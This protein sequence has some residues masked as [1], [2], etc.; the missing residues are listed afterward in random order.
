[1]FTGNQGDNGVKMNKITR[2]SHQFIFARQSCSCEE[3]LTLREPLKWLRLYDDGARSGGGTSEAKL[4]T[5]RSDRPFRMPVRHSIKE[6]S[7]LIWLRGAD[8][9]QS[10]L[11]SCETCCPM[12]GDQRE[13]SDRRHPKLIGGW[14]LFPCFLTETWMLGWMISWHGATRGRRKRF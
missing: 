1:M 11:F 12:P 4:R 13:S 3:P 5:R 7:E 10:A 14:K 6:S 9:S 8:T 2:F